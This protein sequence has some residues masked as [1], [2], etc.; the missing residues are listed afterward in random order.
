MNKLLLAII[1][2]LLPPLAVDCLQ[3]WRNTLTAALFAARMRVEQHCAC[4]LRRARAVCAR[5]RPSVCLCAS[6][7]CTMCA[8]G[9]CGVCAASV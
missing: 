6:G 7:V 1:A 4:P 3:C 2:I 5:G 8:A 9:V